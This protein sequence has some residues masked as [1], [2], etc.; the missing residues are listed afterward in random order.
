[1]RIFLLAGFA[2]FLSMCATA[3]VTALEPGYNADTHAVV[4]CARFSSE[5]FKGAPLSIVG[6]YIGPIA[7]YVDEILSAAIGTNP[8]KVDKLIAV[9]HAEKEEVVFIG[10]L[11]GCVLYITDPFDNTFFGRLRNSLT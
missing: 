5:P 2:L 3:P 11:N 8:D 1:M 7:V 10:I 9:M 4:E 6:D